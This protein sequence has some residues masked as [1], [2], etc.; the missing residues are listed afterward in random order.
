MI[1][2]R[3]RDALTFFIIFE[4]FILDDCFYTDE[5][6]KRFWNTLKDKNV[7][8]K[9]FLQLPESIHFLGDKDETSIIYICKYYHDLTKIAFDKKDCESAVIRISKRRYSATTYFIYFRKKYSNYI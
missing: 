6:V 3:E 8:C 2:Q 9:D 7:E 1:D 5:D 4:S